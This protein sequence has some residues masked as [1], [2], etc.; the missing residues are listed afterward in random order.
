MQEI[1][2][3]IGAGYHHSRQADSN[4]TSL[5]RQAL[6][7]AERIINIGAGTGS[8]EPEDARLL[9]VEPSATMIAQRPHNAHPAILAR[10]DDIPVTDQSF[11]HAM[12]VLSMHHWPDRAAAFAEIKRITSQKFIAV[13]WL[14][15]N[16]NFWLT[17]DY[18]PE[19]Q[20]IDEQIFPSEAEWQEHFSHTTIQPIMIP[21]DCQDGFLAAFWQR[22]ERYLDARVRQAMST[23]GKIK[24]LDEGLNRL[25]KDLANGAWH[26]RYGQLLNEDSFDAGYRLFT[27]D[28][29][30]AKSNNT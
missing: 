10:A 27:A 26:R 16:H 28:L 9:A 6:S 11:T 2:D 20:T 13:T 29:E 21:A 3:R 18:F 12:T 23:F 19:I 7:G 24:H 25:R 17:A 1:Y 8:Y 5:I 15:E 22:P 4:L 30:A 14:P